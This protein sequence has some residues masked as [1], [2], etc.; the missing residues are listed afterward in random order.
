MSN[1]MTSRP[2]CS[3][4]SHL[5]IADNKECVAGGSLSDDVISVAVVCLRKRVKEMLSEADSLGA[6]PHKSRCRK[7]TRSKG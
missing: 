4:P 1:K 2:F 6:R 5:A 3:V 7:E